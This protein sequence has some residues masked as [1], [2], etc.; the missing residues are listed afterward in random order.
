MV[1]DVI[2]TYPSKQWV[3]Y[4]IVKSLCCTSETDITLYIKYTSTKKQ[5]KVVILQS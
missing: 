1:T 4:R 5:R 2:Y 3:M